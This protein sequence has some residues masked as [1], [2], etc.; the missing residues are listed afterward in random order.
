VTSDKS[1]RPAPRPEET[2]ML[3]RQTVPDVTV[4]G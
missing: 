1:I 4:T 2:N 3:H